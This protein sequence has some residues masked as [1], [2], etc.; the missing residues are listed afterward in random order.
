MTSSKPR[1]VLLVM[2][3]AA[4]L[5]TA[6]PV[7]ANTG[8]PPSADH[9]LNLTQERVSTDSN[10]IH[11]LS[12]PKL[13]GTTKPEESLKRFRRSRRFGHPRRFRRSGPSRRFGRFR[14]SRGRRF[15]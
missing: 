8:S 6:R 15:H 5:T 13:A 14:R 3:I 9:P 2:A 7:F 10:R 11:S 1:A 4:S 12:T